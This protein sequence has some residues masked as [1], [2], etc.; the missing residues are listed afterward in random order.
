MINHTRQQHSAQ[1]LLIP[2]HV[3]TTKILS[4][5]IMLTLSALTATAQTSADTTSVPLR[6]VVVTGTRSAVDVR[7][8]P[9]TV[10]VIPRSELT[11]SNRL[12]ILPTLTEDVPGLFVTSRSML[13][14]AV[15]TN[16]AGSI[17]LRGLSAGSGQL[18]VLIDGHPQYQGVYGHSISDGLQ[19]QLAEKVEVLRT[20]A[21]VLYGSN[22]MGGVI[23]VVTR[24]PQID[25]VETN[26]NLGV[27]SYGTAM[28]EASNQVKAGRFSSTVSANYQRTDNNRP[29]MGFD[30][31]GGFLKLNYDIST[32]WN[33]YLQSDLTHFNSSN[34]G[35]TTRPL[36]DARQW[37]TRGSTSLFL[38][39]HYKNTSGALSVYSNYG[40]HK[41]NDGVNDPTTSPTRYFRSRD[42]LTG[43]SLYQSATFWTGSRLTLGVDWQNIYGRAFYT[44]IHTGKVLETPNK[45]SGHSH[46]NDIAGYVDV[47]QDLLSWLTLDAGIRLDHHSITGN[48]WVPQGGFVIRPMDNA[49]L[50]ATVSKGFRNPSMRE[51]YLYPPSNEDLKPERIVEYELAWKHSLTGIGLTYGVNLFY[52]YGSNMIQTVRIDGRPRNVNTG[53]I[54]NSGAELEVNYRINSHYTLST[55]HS[56]LHMHNHVLAAPEYKGTLAATGR[57]GAWGARLSLMQLAGLFTQTSPDKTENATLLSAD[58]SFRPCRLVKLWLRG[59]NLLAQKYEINAGFPMPRATVMGGVSLTF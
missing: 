47:R 34:P 7:H 28:V 38:E 40:R 15:S 32:N 29:H 30:Q 51:L 3:K 9:Y 57:W 31:Y 2:Y 52:I 19:T 39:N 45:Q 44:D 50:K 26:V 6:D 59:E 24:Q 12:N 16:A 8:L 54:E 37:I 46:R 4:S 42:V 10:T 43:I 20:P 22:A 41:I 27:G 55:T 11:Y 58:I 49:S 35:P 17:S 18:L 56:V 21:S 5:A 14:Y 13:G 25:G 1:Q 36:Y 33:V 48:E 23:N 53:K